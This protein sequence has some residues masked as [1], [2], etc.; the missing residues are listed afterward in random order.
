MLRA[1]GYGSRTTPQ[2]LLIFGTN[3]VIGNQLRAADECAR[4]KIL[5]CLGDF[6]LLGCDL[7]GH[8]DAYRTGHQMNRD[9][10]ARLKLAQGEM[11]ERS[12]RH[13]A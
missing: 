1:Q 7:Y 4:H 8:F 9:L 6:A 5:D 10:I 13:A 11:G 2:D 3:G 12:I